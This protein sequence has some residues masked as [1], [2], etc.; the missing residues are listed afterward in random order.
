MMLMAMFVRMFMLMVVFTVVMVMTAAAF[1]TVLMMMVMLMVVTAAAFLIVLMVMLMMMFML[2][3]GSFKRSYDHSCFN[4]VGSIVYFMQEL[5]GNVAAYFKLPE[6]EVQHCR[7]YALKLAD[8][9]F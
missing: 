5:I 4:G 3:V 8:S 9:F 2:V 1:I 7:F 6:W